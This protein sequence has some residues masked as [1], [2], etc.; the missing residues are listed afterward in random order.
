LADQEKLAVNT[1]NILTG[2]ANL[3]VKNAKWMLATTDFKTAMF[4]VGDADNKVFDVDDS[5]VKKM[6]PSKTM[7]LEMLGIEYQADPFG[8]KIKSSR[9]G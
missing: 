8:F 4:K 9:D 3:L 5:I 1:P 2:T 6:T 7:K